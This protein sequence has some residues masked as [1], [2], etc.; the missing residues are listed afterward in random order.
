[1]YHKQIAL[2][3]C[4]G[5]VLAMPLL[6]QFPGQI[7]TYMTAA[8]LRAEAQ[9]L[10]SQTTISEQTERTRITER[11]KT[12]DTLYNAG[13]MPSATKLRIRR[14]LD[15]P[16][17]DPRPDTTGWLNDETVY[18]YDAAGSCI[19]RIEERRWYWKHRHAA[20]CEGQP[21]Q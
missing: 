16:R 4:G 12:A 19:G 18:V 20:A 21:T 3:L 8:R 11:R 9:T 15:S 13:I 14:Y 6:L 2:G 7:G 1:M 5:A 10:Q 17:R